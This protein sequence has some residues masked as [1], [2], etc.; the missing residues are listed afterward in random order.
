MLYSRPGK[1]TGVQL[2]MRTW[3]E[4]PLWHVGSRL[5]ILQ[6]SVP[7][8][9]GALQREHN[10]AIGGACWELRRRTRLLGCPPAECVSHS[11]PIWGGP[12]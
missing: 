6:K 7:G 2:E 12:Q 4:T 11:Q 9:R 5:F 8:S 3:L 1:Y 10:G